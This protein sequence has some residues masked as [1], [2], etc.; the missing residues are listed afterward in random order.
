METSKL[1]QQLKKLRNANNYT[2]KYVS[3]YLHI[4]RSAYS[5]Y[6]RGSRTPSYEIIS[7]LAV[8]YQISPNTFYPDTDY[9]SPILTK[10]DKNLLELIHS[11]PNN[12]QEEIFDFI[13][14]KKERCKF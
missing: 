5:N 13:L 4:T 12:T 7:S 11:L 1:A 8:L 9:Q 6:E 2:Q 3:D 14:F 10:E